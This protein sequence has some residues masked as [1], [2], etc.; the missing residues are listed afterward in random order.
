MGLL[1]NASARHLQFRLKLYSPLTQLMRVGRWKG[2]LENAFERSPT[3]LL[4]LG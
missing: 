2:R 1:S 3:F 4:F